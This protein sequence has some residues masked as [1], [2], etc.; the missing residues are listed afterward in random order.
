MV[1]LGIVGAVVASFVGVMVW[2]RFLLDQL[3]QPGPG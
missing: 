3:G 2:T 1:L